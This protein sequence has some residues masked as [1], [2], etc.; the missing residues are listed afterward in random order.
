LLGGKA[1]RAVLAFQEEF[2]RVI[3]KIIRK[4]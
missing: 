3:K 2:K 4:S 1:N